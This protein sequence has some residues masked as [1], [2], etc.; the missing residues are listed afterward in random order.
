MN[1]GTRNL[2]LALAL[3][4]ALAAPALAAE[5][6]FSVRL[7]TPEAALTAARA[8]LEH[9]RKAGYQVGVAVV[10]RAGLPHVFLRDRYAG[11][12]TVEVAINKAWT[13]ASFRIP[14][15][16]L[17]KETQAG[18][19][20]SGLRTLPRVMA[21]GGGQVIE[22]AGTVVGAIAVSGAPGGAADDACA[23]AG[24]KAIADALEF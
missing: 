13:A 17:A 14:T 18:S 23:L 16:A 12:H 10:D 19:E 22:S 4:H 24:I 21:A 20:M 8:A 15:A 9:C 2:S 5:A 1:R 3:L 11:A 6:T 7:L